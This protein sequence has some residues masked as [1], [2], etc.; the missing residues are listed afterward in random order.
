MAVDYAIR[1][2]VATITLNRPEAMNALDPETTAALD[3]LWRRVREDDQVRVVVVTGTG[4]RAFCAGAD[5]KKTMPPAES[6]AQLTFGKDAGGGKRLTTDK[7]IIAAING[8]ALG[9]GL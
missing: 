3:A 7:P 8:L 1:E 2:H 5:L 9:G 4:D 6:F